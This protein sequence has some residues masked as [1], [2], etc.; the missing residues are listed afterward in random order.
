MVVNFR[1]QAFKFLQKSSP[2]LIAEIRQ[3]LNQ[4]DTAIELQSVI[5]FTELDIK[6]MKGDWAGYYR[7]RIGDVR[8][9]FSVD[10]KSGNVDVY[11]IGSRGDVYK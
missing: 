5:P 10:D 4:I 6:K 9:I 1:K 3:Q 2:N 11:K 8:V 7:L